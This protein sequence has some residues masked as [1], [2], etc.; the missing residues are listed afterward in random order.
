MSK[1]LIQKLDNFYNE[2]L[3]L[4]P[5]KQ[6]Y[7]Q[8]WNEFKTLLSDASTTKQTVDKY[9]SNMDTKNLIPKPK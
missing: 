2:A 6:E 3:G 9:I 8:A 4:I 7:G 1:N 5:E